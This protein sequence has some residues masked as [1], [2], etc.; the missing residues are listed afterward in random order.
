MPSS[1]LFARIS[2]FIVLSLAFLLST[3]RISMAFQV[4]HNVSPA[5]QQAIDQG[6]ADASQEINLTVYLKMPNRAAF[7]AAVDQLYNPASP[8]YEKW[9]TDAELQKYA[10]SP[11]QVAA[12][13]NE[14][15]KHGLTVISEDP[16]GFSIR[17]HGTI[18]N[19]ESA[20]QTE[21]HQFTLKNKTFRANIE[22]AKLTGNAASLVRSVAGLV[23]H[24]ARPMPKRATNLAAGKT[25]ASMPLKTVEASGGLNSILTENC[26]TAPAA[27]TYTTPGSSLPVGV[28]FGNVYGA[29]SKECGYTPSGLEAH[30]GLSAAYRA[31]FSGKGQTIA[32]VEGYGY[33]TIESDANAFFQLAGLPLLNSSNF[34]IV[35]PEGPPK[36][37]NAG[38]LT[39]WNTEIA[40]DLQSAHSIAPLAKIIVVAAA[41]Q[42]NE[43]L[44]GA[45]DYVRSHHLANVV[46]NSWGVDEEMLAGPLELASFDAL[47]EKAAAQGVSVHFA[48]GDGGD[49]GFGTPIGSPEVPADNPYSTAVGG[50]SIL[51]DPSGTGYEELGW[52]MDQ[53]VLANNGLVVPPD[54]TGLY[55]GAGG[56]E[57]IWYAKPSW[58]AALPGSGRQVPDVS[59]LADPFTGVAIVITVDGVQEVQAGWG[60]TSLA[61]PIFSAFW[62]LANQS[63]GHSLG[64]AARRIAAFSGDQM[65]DIVPHSS[66][67]NAAGTI[68]D[69]AGAHYYSPA[70]LFSDSLYTTTKFIS[71]VWPLGTDTGVDLSFGTD[72]SLTVTKGWDNV[73]GFGVPNGLAFITGAS[74]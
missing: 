54:Q 65:I 10:P 48:S 74:K 70:D 64:Q 16:L 17:V 13:R 18:A 37:P 27:F 44:Q 50:T 66:P 61:C 6:P 24:Q 9:M 5:V 57:S 52:G 3:S 51:N 72:S 45:I 34:E 69:Q 40:I 12:V 46:S 23:G 2:G 33:P 59:A 28:Y 32:L 73:T 68:F 8:S 26:L 60:G 20:F 36:N 63:A 22:D 62:A 58:Q 67:T 7:D 29:G 41:G 43:D 55:G 14:L 4:E 1:R 38:I 30:Y 47:L 42:D 19:V 11:A 53:T 31:G 39:G 56:G 71:A 15:Q 35:Y 25:P 49:D 21:I